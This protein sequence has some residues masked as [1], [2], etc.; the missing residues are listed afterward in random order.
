MILPGGNVR[1]GRIHGQLPTLASE[2]L[3]GPGGPAATTD[4]RDVLG[5]M[6]QRRWSKPNLAEV[7]PK[8]KPVFRREV[9]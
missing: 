2:T 4:Y 1:G 6:V 9:N 5:E 7:F 3:V 8:F